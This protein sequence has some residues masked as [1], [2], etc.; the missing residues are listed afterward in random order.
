MT[1]LKPPPLNVLLIGISVSIVENVCGVYWNPEG[2]HVRAEIAAAFREAGE[3][4]SNEKSETLHLDRENG[5]ASCLFSHG[6]CARYSSDRTEG[7]STSSFNHRV[8]REVAVGAFSDLL[9]AHH[10]H[11]AAAKPC[12]W[13]C[14]ATQAR[15]SSAGSNSY[16][17]HSSLDTKWNENEH[18]QAEGMVLALLRQSFPNAQVRA[19]FNVDG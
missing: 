17:K 4:C 15:N 16:K 6:S 2:R 19:I 7:T 9:E 10:S 3:W 13:C 5:G 8:I 11:G 12:K 14:G 1:V 18:D